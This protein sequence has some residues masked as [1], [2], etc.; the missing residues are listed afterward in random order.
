MD[1]NMDKVI[2]ATVELQ[3]Q[4]STNSHPRDANIT[5]NSVDHSY[6]IKGLEDNGFCSVTTFIRTLFKPFNGKEVVNR[7]YDKWQGDPTS[8][9]YNMSKEAILTSWEQNG[10]QM[11]ELGTRMHENIEKYYLGGE[12]KS[13]SEEW[14]YFKAFEKWYQTLLYPWVPYR[15]EW[16]I[17]HEELRLAGCLDMLFI[18]EKGEFFLCDWKRCKQIRTENRFQKGTRPCTRHLDDCNYMHYSIQLLTYAYILKQKYDIQVSGCYIINFHP[19]ERQFAKYKVYNC[20]ETIQAIMH[21]RFKTMKPR[22]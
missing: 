21:H 5:F 15:S 8:N 17:Y 20:E 13:E 7:C 6:H 10:T 2:A 3:C 19:N 1:M 4:V 16:K 18:N 9:Y 11:A 14:Y 12:Y 22:H